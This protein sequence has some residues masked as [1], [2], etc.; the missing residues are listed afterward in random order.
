MRRQYR[1]FAIADYKQTGRAYDVL[2]QDGDRE[3]IFVALEGWRPSH[4]S[5]RRGFLQH[6]IDERRARL[7]IDWN[8]FNRFLPLDRPFRYFALTDAEHPADRPL[9]VVRRWAEGADEHEEHLVSMTEWAPSTPPVP[10]TAEAVPIDPAAVDRFAAVLHERETGHE[11]YHYVAIV[12]DEHTVENPRTVVRERPATGEFE[13]YT[14][15]LKWEPGDAEGRRVPIGFMTVLAF[16]TTMAK[17]LRKTSPHRYY[18]VVTEDHP[19][20][21]APAALVRH[22]ISPCCLPYDEVY[23]ANGQWVRTNAAIAIRAGERPGRVVPITAAAADA[24]RET[25]TPEPGLEQEPV[26]RPL[27]RYYAVDDPPTVV[28]VRG[29][30]EEVYTEALQW[31]RAETGGERVPI[32]AADA[33]RFEETQ[34]RRVFGEATFRYYAVVNAFHPDPEDPAA[35]VRKVV[36]DRNVWI[37][38]VHG[39]QWI[40]VPPFDERE[41]VPVPPEKAARLRELCGSGPDTPLWCY[42]GTVGAPGLLD[43]LVRFRNDLGAIRQ[44]HFRDGAWHWTGTSAHVRSSSDKAAHFEQPFD[45]AAVRSF[46]AHGNPTPPPPPEPEYT[47]CALIEESGQ[48]PRPAAGLLRI[49]QEGK[50]EREEQFSAHRDDWSISWVREDVSRGDKDYEIIGISQVEALHVKEMLVERAVEARAVVASHVYYAITDAE[51]PLRNPL[52]LIRTWSNKGLE[53]LEE[54]TRATGYGAWVQRR[55]RPAGHAVRLTESNRH[56]VEQRIAGG[57]A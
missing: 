8:T 23:R 48:R 46:V 12:D 39:D 45:I 32:T 7:I 2:R 43:T 38:E 51:H 42:R 24:L 17:R 6:E 25:W 57:A 20:V 16:E 18:A 11:F 29:D 14:E 28:R 4:V 22:H 50:R 37:T 56:R 49:S 34:F 13:R 1:Y 41:L 33:L 27:F 53:M 36:D 44:E 10:D 15:N 3:E 35:V 52:A 19:D 5:E 9:A 40:Y 47:Y 31:E 21:T 55:D 30:I 26:W 54:Y